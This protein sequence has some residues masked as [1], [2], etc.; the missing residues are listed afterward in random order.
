MT[1][2]QAYRFALDP[3]QAQLAGIRRHAGA[4]RFAYNWGLARVKAA[5]A[6]RD[7]EQSYG[8]TGDLLT[9]VPWTLPALRLAWN[10]VKRDI[11]PWWDECSKEAFRAGLDQLARGLKNVTDSRQGKRKGRRVGFPR[12]KKRGRARDS[13][14]YTTGAYG[15][16]DETYVKLPRIGRVKVHEPMGALTGRLADG[17][18]RLLGVTVSRTADRWFVSFTVEVDRDVPERPSRRQRA[19]G[20]VGVDLG[21]K[22]LAVLST[23]QT[24]P[25]PKHY[26]RAERRLRRASRAHARSKP[27]SAGRR[28]RAAQL[29][30]IHVRVANQRHN[31][32][33]KLTTRLARSHDTVVVEDLHVAGMVRNRRLARAVA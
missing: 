9:P 24:V 15:P 11:A 1:T 4:S 13:F 27:G 16:A 25:N 5:H 33:H 10:A 12:F 32:L 30:T 6:Q 23:G 2:L 22:H 19:G 3:N 8:L 31:G 28:Q 26:Q 20:P 14:R 29:A 21:V 18:A 17:R 7:A